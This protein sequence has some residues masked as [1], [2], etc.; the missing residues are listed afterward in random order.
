MDRL[1]KERRSW[2]MSRIQGRDTM[3]ERAVC[4][5]VRRA[6]V[7]FRMHARELPGRPDI[8]LPELHTAIFVHGCFWHRHPRCKFAYTPKSRIE[9]WRKKFAENVAR[10]RR[11]SRALRQSGWHVLNIWECKTMDQVQLFRRISREISRLKGRAYRR[12]S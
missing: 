12:T 5:G 3:P 1:S 10:D 6:G 8:V 9:F 7:R 11:A 4:S 2:N